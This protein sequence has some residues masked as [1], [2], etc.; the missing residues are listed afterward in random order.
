M[1]LSGKIKGENQVNRKIKRDCAN[2]AEP[3]GEMFLSKGELC[4]S[5]PQK[6]GFDRVFKVAINLLSGSCY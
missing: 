6:S 3:Q 5:I 2:A 4:P 1:W